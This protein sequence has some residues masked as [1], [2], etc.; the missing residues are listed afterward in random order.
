MLQITYAKINTKINTAFVKACAKIKRDWSETWR[1][2]KRALAHDKNIF[3]YLTCTTGAA[4]EEG[5]VPADISF[6]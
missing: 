1:V 2:H 3:R 6:R 5:T 4:R